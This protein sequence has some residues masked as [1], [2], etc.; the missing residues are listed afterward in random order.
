MFVS[1]EIEGIEDGIRAFDKQSLAS[2][3]EEVIHLQ[4]LVNDLTELSNAEIGAISYDKTNLDLTSLLK[5]NILRHQNKA[6]AA[7][8]SLLTEMKTKKLMVWADETRINQLFDNLINNSIKYSDASG[9]IVITLSTEN[10]RVIIMP[11]DTLPKVPQPSLDKLAKLLKDNPSV[12]IEIHSHA[13]SRGGDSYN[14]NLSNQ[15]AQSVVNYF[16]IF[17]HTFALCLPDFIYTIYSVSKP[18][19]F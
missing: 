8:L 1:S 16:T 17:E 19:R 18:K 6:N 12:K 5:Q 13:D 14:M 3:S 11:I 9:E 15:R 10:N 2:L 7:G 4:K